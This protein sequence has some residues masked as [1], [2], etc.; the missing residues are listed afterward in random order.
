MERKVLL[1]CSAVGLLGLL[2]AA[3][4]FAAEGTRIKGSQVQFV[5]NT[6]CEYPRSPALGLGVTAAVAL[7]LAHII[8]NVST[9]CIC[10]KRSPHP[11]NSNW[12]VALFC[13]VFS[14]FLPFLLLLFLFFWFKSTCTLFFPQEKGNTN[15]SIRFNWINNACVLLQSPHWCRFTF[16][17]AFLLLLTGA[18][19]ND[20][21]GVESM[22][23]GSYYCYVVKPGVFA[24]GAILS[25]AC[26]ALGI[27]YYVILNS[28][29]NG[30]TSW[31]GSA[32]TQGTIAMGQQLQIP[33]QSTT[34]QE[35]VFVHEDTQKQK[36]ELEAAFGVTQ[37][38]EMERKV[39]PVCWAVGL[40]GMQ[41]AATRYGNERMRI[42]L[43]QV[44]FVTPA[45][46]EY[47]TTP[48][49]GLGVTAAAALS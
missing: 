44:K 34:T 1:V 6:Q 43:S 16:V 41:S 27:V 7:M 23:F 19:L 46:C 13:F 35:P 33:P 37:K 45:Q 48:A 17:I 25:F 22:Y 8:V 38:P 36:S 12:T 30:D 18:A 3:T 10:C 5:S 9:G 2:S 14:C 26:V 32:P 31:G 28:A 4:G 20:R 40:L 29:K 11:T 47:P 39:L 15:L 42:E 24:G 21:H 49:F